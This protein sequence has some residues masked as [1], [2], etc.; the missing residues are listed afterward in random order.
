MITI[1]NPIIESALQLSEVIEVRRVSINDE[2]KDH[3]N[4]K[5]IPCNSNH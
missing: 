3:D 5:K 4:N 1:Y 2:E